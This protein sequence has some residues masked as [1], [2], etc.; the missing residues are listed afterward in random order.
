MDFDDTSKNRSVFYVEE[1]T[2]NAAKTSFSVTVSFYSDTLTG[3]GVVSEY[4]EFGL[5]ILLVGSGL[6]GSSN[7][8]ESSYIY[9]KMSAL[10]DT[11][12]F[13]SA[14]ADE[15][16]AQFDFKNSPSD[17]SPFNYLA[18]TDLG[19]GCGAVKKNGKMIIETAGCEKNLFIGYVTGFVNN[20]LS[21]NQG[22]GSNAF[23]VPGPNQV[24][25]TI[26]PYPNPELEDVTDAGYIFKQ[27]AS[28]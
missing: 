16:T 23:I 20:L 18:T 22:T 1:L 26:P 13:N 25:L 19:S 12:D 8:V 17:T 7:T 2:I 4:N 24:Y 27:S 10:R 3:G 5:S 21:A 14:D 28:D 15:N 6:S 11:I 9:A